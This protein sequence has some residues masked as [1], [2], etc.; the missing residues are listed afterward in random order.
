[1]TL[2]QPTYLWG[3][4]SL[5]IPII[6]HLLNKGDV[7]TIKVG[8][9]KY[10]KEFDTKQ[11]RKI[12][13]NELLLLFLRILLLALLVF[14]LATPRWKVKS[15]RA[16]ITYL[17]EPSLLEDGKI[18]TVLDSLPRENLRL[19]SKGFP[20]ITED[21]ENEEIPNYWQLAQNLSEIQ[22]DSFVLFTKGLLSGIKGLRPKI[23]KNINWVLV[24]DEPVIR[25]F[26][27]ARRL[28]DSV[29]LYEVKSNPQRTELNRTKLSQQDESIISASLDSLELKTENGNFKIPLL[30]NDTLNV[31]IAFDT[32]YEREMQYISASLK[33]IAQYGLRKIHV[34][35]SD[36]VALI[37]LENKVDLLV[38]LRDD[39]P[40]KLGLTT[41]TLQLD[42]LTNSLIKTT[43]QK[44]LY[45]L[46]DRL[47]ISNTIA[48]DLTRTLAQLL[49]KN[50][51]ISKNMELLDQRILPEAEIASIYSKKEKS[52]QNFKTMDMSPWLWL[53]IALVLIAERIIA[54]L[55]KQ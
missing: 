19:F 46:T 34:E 55:R 21:I 18:Q 27:G 12:R 17:I 11:S 7:K 26:V 14:Y 51:S 53:A 6:I 9:V 36:S 39:L 44:G 49:L 15:N 43:D 31:A 3:L 16:P 38:W 10:L 30:A 13:L 32:N 48:S 50:D 23:P 33:A 52:A 54:K 2:L 5:F 25:E 42:T 1:M 37:N 29:L 8:S 47:T 35:K 41:I 20:A 22:S 40:D 28:K 24:N 45:Q 4:L